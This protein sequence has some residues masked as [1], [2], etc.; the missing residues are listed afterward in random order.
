MRRRYAM[1]PHLLK[2]MAGLCSD[3]VP[4]TTKLFGDNL[5]GSLK[6]IKELERLT[7]SSG[8][9]TSG[10]MQDKWRRGRNWQNNGK[11]FLGQRNQQFAG[12]QKGQ[13]GGKKSHR[14]PYH[15]RA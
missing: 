5:S 10:S 7:Q 14:P 2:E 6:E 15:K 3:N 12:T 1:R 11:A 4:I 9:S 8:P 13:F